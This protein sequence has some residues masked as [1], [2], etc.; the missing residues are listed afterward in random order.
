MPIPSPTPSPTFDPV[1]RPPASPLFFSFEFKVP[2]VL[3]LDPD[4]EGFDEPAVP[5]VEVLD[6]PELFALS[7]L[8][9]SASFQA[10]LILYPFAAPDVNVMGRLDVPPPA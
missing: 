5:D 3:K 9:K 6:D 1:L 7:L 2:P 10:M 8:V 4:P